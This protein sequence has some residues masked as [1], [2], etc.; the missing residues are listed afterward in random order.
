MDCCWV[1]L[2]QNRIELILFLRSFAGWAKDECEFKVA[3]IQT[4][5]CVQDC[6][7]YHDRNTVLILNTKINA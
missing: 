7:A 1:P 4:A 3:S 2:R 5:I 6:R